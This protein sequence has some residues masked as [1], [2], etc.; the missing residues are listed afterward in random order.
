MPCRLKGGSLFLVAA[1]V[2]FGAEVLS[3]EPLLACVTAG[4]VI[5]NRRLV[6]LLSDPCRTA[7]PPLLLLHVFGSS[8]I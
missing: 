7:A 6:L 4:L 8:G 1:A 3:A 5:A 2:F